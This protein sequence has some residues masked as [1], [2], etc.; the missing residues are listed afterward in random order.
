MTENPEIDS[1]YQHFI[2]KLPSVYETRWFARKH[3]VD[4]SEN[5]LGTRRIQKERHVHV[6]GFGND[7]DEASVAGLTRLVRRAEKGG[8]D[9]IHVENRMPLRNGA[10]YQ[11]CV[12]AVLYKF[13]P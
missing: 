6:M 13:K 2:D 4:L 1:L 10:N 9:C 3:D 5:P 11:S 8:Y 12:S 7:Y